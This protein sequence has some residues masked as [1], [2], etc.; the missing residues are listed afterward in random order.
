GEV[1]FRRRRHLGVVREHA[2]VVEQLLPIDGSVCGL[3]QAV[4]EEL[5]RAKMID[6]D[7]GIQRIVHDTSRVAEC[8]LYSK[9]VPAA[10]RGWGVGSG[11]DLPRRGVRSRFDAV[12]GQVSTGGQRWGQVSS[13]GTRVGSRPDPND[14][15][16]SR[17][18]P[19][20]SEIET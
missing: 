5:E 13:P 4:G 1:G 16:R 15:T 3:A 6:G 17:P 18:D 10:P 19:S 20:R 9:D 11:L 14:V 7:Q 2:G 8:L 12:W